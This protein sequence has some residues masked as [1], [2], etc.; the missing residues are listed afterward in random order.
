MSEN[1]AV[2]EAFEMFEGDIR[3][4]DELIAQLELWSDMYTINHKKE[5][6]R[7]E[8]YVELANNL[9]ELQNHLF[10]TLEAYIALGLTKEQG[11]GY[12]NMVEEKLK[13]FR[14]TEGIIHEWI[15]NIENVP[16]LLAKS[17]LLNEHRAFIEEITVV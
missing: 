4:L 14:E 3:K 15:R 8:E 1:K 10:C 12:K 17:P 7:L 2:E 9:K 13:K 11:Q 6:T 5:Q 16:L